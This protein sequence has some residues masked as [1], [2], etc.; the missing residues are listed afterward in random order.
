MILCSSNHLFNHIRQRV[1]RCILEWRSPWL[2]GGTHADSTLVLL[3]LLLFVP[4]SPQK[5]FLLLRCCVRVLSQSWLARSR[6]TTTRRPVVRVGPRSG[7]RQVVCLGV[8]R[9]FNDY[10]L[11]LH[12][13]GS[14]FH[15]ALDQVHLALAVAHGSLYCQSFL[16][17]WVKATVSQ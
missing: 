9:W 5:R 2:A 15:M 12:A 17:Q 11:A 3:T 10:C 7:G 14:T 4:T 16:R 6:I 13:F 1:E 8:F